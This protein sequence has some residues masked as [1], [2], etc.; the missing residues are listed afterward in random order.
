MQSHAAK[1]LETG[2]GREKEASNWVAM[3]S[4]WHVHTLAVGVKVRIDVPSRIYQPHAL[5]SYRTRRLSSYNVCYAQVE[6]S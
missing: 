2:W 5:S 1:I 6:L 3:A 4:E